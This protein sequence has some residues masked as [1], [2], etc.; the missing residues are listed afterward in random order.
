MDL[1]DYL[2]RMVAG[3][4]ILGHLFYVFMAMLP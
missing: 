2:H 4:D 1:I 3:T